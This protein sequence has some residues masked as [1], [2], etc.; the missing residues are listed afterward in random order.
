MAA[1][2]AQA[3]AA[4]LGKG[5]P[6]LKRA[7]SELEVAAQEYSVARAPIV[8][9]TATSDAVTI[10]FNVA[11]SADDLVHAAQSV[12][13]LQ[14]AAARSGHADEIVVATNLRGG[15]HGTMGMGVT[16]SAGGAARGC[17]GMLAALPSADE[18]PARAP[19]GT[20]LQL[21]KSANEPA[22]VLLDVLAMQLWPDAPQTRGVPA[23][24]CL[25]QLW[26]RC[27][28]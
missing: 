16:F 4:E 18:R 1:A 13:R 11:L 3:S 9:V 21:P 26:V 28:C 15:P 20:P 24:E 22:W 7:R 6:A 19:A 12:A 27:S 5:A 25:Q 17:L 8:K 10:R 23:Q 14:C 2:S